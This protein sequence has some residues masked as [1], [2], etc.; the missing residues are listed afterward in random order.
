MNSVRPLGRVSVYENK[1][2]MLA[3]NHWEIFFSIT[4]TSKNQQLEMYLTKD[5]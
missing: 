2:N 1:M 5:I 3:A 4:I